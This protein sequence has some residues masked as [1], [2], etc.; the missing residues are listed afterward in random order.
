MDLLE[1]V[2]FE[3]SIVCNDNFQLLLRTGWEEEEERQGEN[4]RWVFNY[5]WVSTSD[6]A[7][8]LSLLPM[9]SGRRG[10]FKNR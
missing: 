1:F 6:F 2:D 9:I 8:F 5:A 10:I 3:S 7:N 4:I